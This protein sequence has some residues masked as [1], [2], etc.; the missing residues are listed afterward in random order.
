M[1][2]PRWTPLRP[3]PL[4]SQY[5]NSPHRFNVLPCGRRSGKTELAKRKLVVR[6][7]EG[8]QAAYYLVHSLDSADFEERDA[9]AALA[10][11]QASADQG[12]AQIVYLGGLG[13][14][15]D[16]LSAHLRSRREVEK[17]LGKGG[18]PV[19]VLRAGIIIG[20]GGISWE[21]TR[22]LV[23]HLP[24]L[25]DVE[26][27][28]DAALAPVR[29]VEDRGEVAALHDRVDP[30]DSSQPA[31]RVASFRVLDLDDL[32]TPVCQYR[33]RRGHGPA[34]ARPRRRRPT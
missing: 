9:D 1:L 14:D 25:G 32:S 4:Q 33:A 27:H 21:I 24:G 13:D 17:L 31:L 3:H 23:E 30:E 20:H 29:A 34:T 18:V 7:V 10:F 26:R 22:Q 28:A 11:G 12:L 2:T 5:F 8:C 15:E 19:T 16:D 6:A